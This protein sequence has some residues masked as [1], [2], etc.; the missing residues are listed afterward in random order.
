M[1]AISLRAMRVLAV[2]LTF[3]SA[4]PLIQGA[5]QAI[6]I[7]CLLAVGIRCGPL[8]QLTTTTVIMAGLTGLIA[9][10]C[11][12]LFGRINARVM[13]VISS[14]IPSTLVILWIVFLPPFWTA[15]NAGNA[16]TLSL[17]FGRTTIVLLCFVVSM[18]ACF[19]ITETLWGSAP[20]IGE[21]P[22]P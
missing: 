17:S 15:T 1:S 14:V 19:K 13:F 10:I 22:P 8:W 4:G 20:V 7:M 16:D 3:L 21:L 12:M 2:T 9:G 6:F 11:E 5:L 18:T